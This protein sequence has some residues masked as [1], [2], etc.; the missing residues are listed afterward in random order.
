MPR[1]FR[2]RMG[3]R[4]SSTQEEVT[5]IPTDLRRPRCIGGPW[6]PRVKCP[7]WH[8]TGDSVYAHMP[9]SIC[10]PCT[11]ATSSKSGRVCACIETDALGHK[12]AV[13]RAECANPPRR[14]APCVLAGPSRG[15]KGGRVRAHVPGV[16][17]ACKSAPPGMLAR[18]VLRRRHRQLE[19]RHAAL[20]LARAC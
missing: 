14:M 15:L 5:K 18:P 19:A 1:E 9:S 2:A 6:G 12:D 16:R 7:S 17:F 11:S 10:A 20:R 8:S 13:P 4:P 3:A